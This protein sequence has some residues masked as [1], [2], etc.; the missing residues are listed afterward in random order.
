ME[1]IVHPYVDAVIYLGLGIQSNQ[2]RMMR[3]GRFY[4]DH[5]LERIVAY[6]ERQDER[7]AEAAH[8]LSSA[9]ASRSWSP[10]NSRSPIRTTPVRPRCVH[11]VGSATRAASEPPRPWSPGA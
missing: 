4:P 1:L 3:E 2:A 5:G 10:P 7:F 11:S 9:P 8:E 6:H